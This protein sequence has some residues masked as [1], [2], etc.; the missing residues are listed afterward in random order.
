M[1]KYCD[2]EVIAT[3]IVAGGRDITYIVVGT[4]NGIES[5]DNIWFI[6]MDKNFLVA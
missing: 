5:T 3:S 2:Y 1:N 6:P 4:R